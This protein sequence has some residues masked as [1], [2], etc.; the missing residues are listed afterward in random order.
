MQIG[1]LVGKFLAAGLGLE[2]L[3]R[4]IRHGHVVHAACFLQ[5]VLQLG[6]LRFQSGHLLRKR[7]VV[8]FVGVRLLL[9]SNLLCFQLV[10]DGARGFSGL[11]QTNLQ[12]SNLRLLLLQLILQITHFSGVSQHRCG[13]TSLQVTDL[14]LQFRAQVVEVGHLLLQSR[15]LG[16]ASVALGSREA[17]LLLEGFVGGHQLGLRCRQLL[18]QLHDRALLFG[19]F[20][21]D[22][23][24]F[25]AVRLQCGSKALLQILNL[26]LQLRNLFL[27]GSGFGFACVD[28]IHS[29]MFLRHELLFRQLQLVLRDRQGASLVFQ[30]GLAST[31]LRGEIGHGG[32]QLSLHAGEGLS[33][34]SLFGLQSRYLCSHCSH[35][36]FA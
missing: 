17:L 5:R 11:S 24:H 35:L 26:I 13:Q 28:L 18:T 10:L 4:K 12:R 33:K 31:E 6:D 7:N 27:V 22:R 32:I 16:H 29:A 36:S 25:C 19:D 34:S 1:D 21:T 23:L 20:H 30:L 15:H 9:R 2:V 14:L 8:C 3:F